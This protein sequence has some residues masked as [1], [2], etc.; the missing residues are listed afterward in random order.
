MVISVPVL[1]AALSPLHAWRD[2]IY[3]AAS[4]AGVLTLSLLLLQL[5]LS[6]DYLPGLG[7]RQKL[8]LH[9]N[10][11]KLLFALV[12]IHVAGLWITSPPDVIDALTFN[13]PTPFSLWGV[14]AMWSLF[15]T[16]TL[17]LFR[18]K[19]NIKPNGWRFI[20]GSLAIVIVFATVIHTVLI[21]GT[22]ENFSKIAICTVLLITTLLIIIKR[23][24]VKTTANPFKR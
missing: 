15:A 14:I 22:M 3:I 19:L 10:T 5:L 21:E 20:H 6:T 16:V 2:S 9:Q 7:R 23:Y 17:A 4:L 1:L 18:S 24:I 11:G 13:S 12:I 8:R